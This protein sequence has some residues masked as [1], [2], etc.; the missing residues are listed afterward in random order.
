MEHVSVVQVLQ[1]Q[2]Q[3]WVSTVFVMALLGIKELHRTA[4]F[5]QLVSHVLLANMSCRMVLRAMTALQDN[6]IT[7]E[8]MLLAVFHAQLEE[9]LVRMLQIVNV[10]M[11][12]HIP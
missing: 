5:L 2:L 4:Q 3:Q 10:P 1:I 12:M 9:L 11:V 6:I 8:Q 7:Y